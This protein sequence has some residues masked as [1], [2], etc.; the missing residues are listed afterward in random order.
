MRVRLVD[1]AARAGVAPNTASTILNNRPGSWASAATRERVTA[2]AAALGYRPSKAARA[3]RL[4]R[5][6]S[7]G[8]VLPDLHNPYYTTFAEHLD[9]AL[10]TEG[11][12][13]VIEHTRNSLAQERHCFDAILERQVDGAFFFVTDPKTYRPF[14][15]LL[16]RRGFPAVILAASAGA[17]LPVDA[18]LVDFSDGVAEAIEHLVGLGHRRVA[19]LCALAEGQDDGQR[20]ALFR[21]LLASHRIPADHMLFVRCGHEMASARA[22]FR[23]MLQTHRDSPPTAVI[24]LNDLSAIGAMRAA[25]DAGLR[26]PH[27]LSVVGVDNIPLGE[28]LPVALTTVAQP[29]PAMAQRA[30]QLLLSR[31][32]APRTSKPRRAVFRTEFLRRESTARPPATT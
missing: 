20:P 17:S 26:V 12:D 29:I 2:A 15:A 18:V 27:D 1:V 23:E 10:K 31:L 3:L 24:A 14:F 25:L 13:L 21:R 8:L 5:H 32:N 30:V 4:G 9:R 11:Y 19:F 28:H 7:I 22:A 16:A 6:H